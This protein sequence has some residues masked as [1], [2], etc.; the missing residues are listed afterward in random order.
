MDTRNF[1]ALQNVQPEELNGLVGVIATAIEQAG[2]ETG[3]R[4]VVYGLQVRPTSPVSMAVRVGPGT[5]RYYSKA[6]LQVDENASRKAVMCR[7][8]TETSISLGVDYLGVST[9]VTSGNERW[10]T[11]VIRSK[12]VTSDPRTP[13]GTAETVN[14]IETE[15]AELI[16]ISGYAT[17]AGQA[18]RPDV[19]AIGIRLADFLLI[20]TTA[21]APTIDLREREDFI[22]SVQGGDLS[23][24]STGTLDGYSLV[25]ECKRN[26]FL[27]G[28]FRL[29]ICHGGTGIGPQGLCLTW[30]ASWDSLTG[31]WF[32]PVDGLPTW[33]VRLTDSGLVLTK[34]S[35]A[36]A[37]GWIE[38]ANGCWDSV[39]TL[40]AG[41]NLI[42]DGSVSF[43]TAVAVSTM[44]GHVT[45]GLG[46][47][48]PITVVINFPVYVPNARVSVVSEAFQSTDHSIQGGS[49][50]DQGVDSVSWYVANTFAI[51][52]I[53]PIAIDTYVNYV[54]KLEIYSYQG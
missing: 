26:E 40:G 46:A 30:N 37:A 31:K 43:T 54:R 10:V 17:T 20:S 6:I 12:R 15:S 38:R 7:L 11:L 14:F 4:G 23:V 18:V 22:Q 53:Q 52:R 42:V 1:F 33:C 21:V 49:A 5:A 45:I 50:A 35:T 47:I 2:F 44:S 41:G 24:N 29:Y 34:K 19:S 36:Q 28:V 8:A 51:L 48:P 27:M 39:V 3:G 32:S 13:L 16:V 9:A 25:W